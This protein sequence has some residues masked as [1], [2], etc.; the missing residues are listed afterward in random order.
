LGD[1][2]TF[3]D[4]V[5]QRD[6]WPNQLVHLLRPELDL[7]LVA[8][9][10]AR[11]I[12]SRDV[13]DEQL[14]GLRELAPQFVSVQ[15]GANDVCLFK[16]DTPALFAENMD[17]ILD[18]VMALV[19]A[20]RMVVLTIPDFTLVPHPPASCAG[21]QSEQSGRIRALNAILMQAAHARG[22]A[23]VDI[24]P[25]ADRVAV[26]P[27]LV[28]SD[29]TYPSAKQYA[30]WADLAALSIR[31]LFREPVGSATGSSEPQAQGP[32]ASSSPPPSPAASPAPSASEAPDRS[33][34][35]SASGGGSSAPAASPA[36]SASEAPDRSPAPSASGGGSSAPAASPAP[37]ASGGGSSAP[38]ASPAPLASQGPVAP[39]GGSPSPSPSAPI[40]LTS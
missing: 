5:R 9:L 28:T 7:D 25:I 40:I 18:T 32:N 3:G 27:S 16:A 23:V 36:P 38:A 12:A 24:S 20:S 17:Q 37:S 26:D 15:V 1:S 33:P 11:S 29:G 34:A 14:P 31:R 19:G 4:G 30:G 39:T 2:Y 21:D 10:A 35:P 22:I 13:V 6:R 8:N